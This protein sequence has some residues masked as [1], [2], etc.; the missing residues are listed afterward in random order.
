[1]GFMN[2]VVRSNAYKQFMS[3]L[4]GW[5]ASIV[6][7]GALFKI[8][9]IKG[10]DLFLFVGLIT[11]SIIFFFSAFEPL[12]IEYDWS[13]VYPELA[14]MDEEKKNKKDKMTG[15]TVTQQ[16]DMMLEEAKIGPALIQSLAD[17]MRNLGDN[18]LKLSG[19]AD[20]AAA[21]DGYVANLNNA[22][23]S[24]GDLSKAYT[25]VAQELEQDARVS[26]EFNTSLKNAAE[27][28]TGLS[29][30]YNQTAES[31]KEDIHAVDDLAR[32][33]KGATNIINN[34][35]EAY[36]KSTE[37]LTKSAEALNFNLPEGN[38]Y[39]EQLRKIS[40][41][42]SALNTVYE[43]QLQSSHKQVD[44]TTKMHETIG[45]FL[46]NLNESVDNTV[47]YKDQ[48]NMLTKNVTALNKVYGNML[49]AM[50]VS[51]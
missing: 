4:Y 17:G 42:L 28:A 9:H 10:A 40:Q 7:L 34:L 14:G 44:A 15:K 26:E 32:S 29:N 31:L 20:A 43:L 50:N 5:G 21:T 38:A 46:Q 47:K 25:K 6:I 48:V 19:V 39:G 23:R 41:N 49:T 18:A 11:E 12:H 2:N 36:A 24:V 51:A 3:K 16:L 35:S 45:S 13:L 8:T 30:I 22:A 27:K 1:M 37:I 33:V